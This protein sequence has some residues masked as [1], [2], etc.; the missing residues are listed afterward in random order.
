MMRQIFF[1]GGWRVGNGLI[2]VS[3]ETVH[4]VLLTRI[5]ILTICFLSLERLRLAIL[6]NIFSPKHDKKI[7]L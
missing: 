5:N 6:I 2:Q 3:K 1:W 4:K 7:F